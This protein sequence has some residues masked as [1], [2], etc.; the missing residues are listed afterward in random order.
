[1]D[2]IQSKTLRTLVV[3]LPDL[4]EQNQICDRY[5]SISK[6]IGSEELN[7]NKLMKQ[8]SGLMHDLL[9][10]N[11]EVFTESLELATH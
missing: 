2:A 9:T 3:P 5:K 10:G 11:V 1:M 6:K 8:K 7:L 4:N